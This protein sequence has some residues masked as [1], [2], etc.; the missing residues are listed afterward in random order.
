MK[1]SQVIS[2]LLLFILG[3]LFAQ[4]EDLSRYDHFFPVS[5]GV[6]TE[7]RVNNSAETLTLPIEGKLVISDGRQVPTTAL[8]L[9][10]GEYR[11]LSRL[12]GGFTFHDIPT[13]IYALDVYNT[14]H[15]FPQL[16]IKVSAENASISL[17]EYKYPGA[18][19]LP[20][21]YPI[22]LQ[23]LAPI[24]YTIPKPP[25]SLL[26]MLMGNPMLLLMLF[27][28]LMAFAMPKVRDTL[29]LLS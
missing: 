24:Q 17:V 10:G 13:G 25:F 23:A 29:C 21:S 8:V 27:T 6:V 1:V 2:S 15:H 12:D 14:A 28:G 22:V 4:C 3:F 20:A 18:S 16:K 9:N 7:H 26:G 11:T 19:R 5:S